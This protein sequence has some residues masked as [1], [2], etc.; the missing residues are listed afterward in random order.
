MHWTSDLCHAIPARFE[1]IMVCF[2]ILFQYDAIYLCESAAT[3]QTEGAEEVAKE[4]LAVP[5][6]RM[7][8]QTN[9]VKRRYAGF[10]FSLICD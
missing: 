5:E 10:F 3:P 9:C 7:V 4:P 8:L 6:P 2:N 1:R